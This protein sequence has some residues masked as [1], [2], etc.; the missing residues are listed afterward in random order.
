MLYD[1]TWVYKGGKC[2]YEKHRQK[3]KHW[4]VHKDHVKG[5]RQVHDGSLDY[6]TV[7]VHYTCEKGLY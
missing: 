2:R 3:Y 5:L 1:K 7:L 4:P 6:N